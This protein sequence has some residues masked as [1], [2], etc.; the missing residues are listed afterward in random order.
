MM[1]KAD[2]SGKT[3]RAQ[4]WLASSSCVAPEAAKTKSNGAQLRSE[5]VRCGGCHDQHYHRHYRRSNSNQRRRPESYQRAKIMSG[6]R[7]GRC[8]SGGGIIN[9][10]CACCCRLSKWLPSR[11]SSRTS[12]EV[13]VAAAAADCRISS[14]GRRRNLLTSANNGGFATTARTTIL[15]ALISISSA[16]C[17]ASQDTTARRRL[18]E[19]VE[20][21]FSLFFF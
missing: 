4:L 12:S 20:G 5:Q 11:T 15:L 14:N 19:P 8:G 3:R 9:S 16:V 21:E 6:Q 13:V 18:G 2:L 7:V 10:S 1:T 17:L